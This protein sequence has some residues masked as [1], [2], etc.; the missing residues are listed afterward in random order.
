[1]EGWVTVGGLQEGYRDM[2]GAGQEGGRAGGRQGRRQAGQ[3]GGR[4]GGRQGRREAGHDGGRAGGRQ[5]MREAGQTRQWRQVLPSL[6][7]S[8]C[9]HRSRTRSVPGDNATSSGDNGDRSVPLTVPVPRQGLAL[10]PSLLTR[11]FTRSLPLSPA[12]SLAALYLRSAGEEA[13]NALCVW[14]GGGASQEVSAAASSSQHES[15]AAS[16]SRADCRADCRAGCRMCF[17]GGAS[18]LDC[19]TLIAIP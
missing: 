9:P 6:L 11:M 4:A 1:V 8:L 15:N 5:G 17:L 12:P 7:L 13:S 2:R 16:T 14:R 10:S 19:H 18:Y 3:E